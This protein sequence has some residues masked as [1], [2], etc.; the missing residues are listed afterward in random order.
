MLLLLAYKALHDRF[1]SP[2]SQKRG[3][4]SGSDAHQFTEQESPNP[5]LSSSPPCRGLW[6]SRSAAAGHIQ[7]HLII[8]IR[9]DDHLS[10]HKHP[11]GLEA[12]LDLYT[13]TRARCFPS[14]TNIVSSRFLDWPQLSLQGYF[15]HTS[16]I[17][18]PLSEPIPTN[19]LSWNWSLL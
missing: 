4:R 18:F 11:G 14:C 8:K 7:Q 9:S 5:Y 6:H 1:Y 12:A 16:N 13:Y 3:T 10:C 2:H 19:L 15:W 17:G